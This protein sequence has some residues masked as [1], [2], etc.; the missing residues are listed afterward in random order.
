MTR[1]ITIF[2]LITAL[3]VGL[4][5]CAFN[6]KNNSKGDGKM[7]HKEDVMKS[8]RRAIYLAGGCFWGVEGYFKKLHG[9]YNTETGYANGKSSD[10][11]YD[12]LKKSDHAETVKIEYDMS[13]IS[14]EELL[15]HF[16]RI[17][18]PKSVNKQGNDEGRQYRTG[19]Y[20][21]TLDSEKGNKTFGDSD[22]LSATNVTDTK[23]SIKNLLEY[24]S[25]KHGKLAVESGKLNNFVKAEDYHQDYLDKNPR[26]YCHI[27]LKL[28]I[29]RAHV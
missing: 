15:L 11:D 17:I 5:A 6:G 26:G 25:K 8:N 22:K 16:F 4:S 9:V 14:L 20:Y 1:Q 10:T 2:I 27:N 13:K 19:I 7:L 18:D 29:G 23:N 21:P 24:E 12:G 28:E 3:I